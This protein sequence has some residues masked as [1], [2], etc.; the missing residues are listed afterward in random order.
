MLTRFVIVTV[1]GTAEPRGVGVSITLGNQSTTLYSK[2]QNNIATSYP[3]LMIHGR[4]ARL[5][6][7]NAHTCV[8]RT[9]SQLAVLHARLMPGFLSSVLLFAKTKLYQ[10]PQPFLVERH[11]IDQAT[12]GVCGIS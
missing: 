8:Q 7:A 11:S 12:L 6:L 2:R 5:T 1:T 4:E 9:R 10:R 3:Q